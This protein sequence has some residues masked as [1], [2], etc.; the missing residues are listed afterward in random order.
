MVSSVS[1]FDFFVLF[2]SFVVVFS[3]LE[4]RHGYRFYRDRRDDLRLTTSG[5]EEAESRLKRKGR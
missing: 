2:V 3:R 4:E 1:F 5:M